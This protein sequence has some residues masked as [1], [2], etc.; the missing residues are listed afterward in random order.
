MASVIPREETVDWGDEIPLRLPGREPIA[1]PASNWL[2][3]TSLVGYLIGKLCPHQIV[4]VG[5]YTGASLLL[6]R[7]LAEYHG[8]ECELYGIDPWDGSNGGVEHWN[9]DGDY[10]YAR[11]R[12][13]CDP[14]ANVHLVR[15]TGDAVARYRPDGSIDLIH[16]DADHREAAIRHDWETWL[17]KLAPGGLILLHDV[18]NFT[19]VCQVWKLWGELTATYPACTDVRGS[20]L[21]IVAPKGVPP[22]L[23]SIL[24][25]Y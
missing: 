24:R 11:L 25:V 15:L 5:V 8:V 20:G 10:V 6:M 19:S 2:N 4:E 9:W 12:E 23:E 17:P 3:H 16:L 22:G 7:A 21:G 14:Y 18:C 1:I 13:R